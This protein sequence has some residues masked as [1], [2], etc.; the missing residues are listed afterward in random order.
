MIRVDIEKAVLEA[1]AELASGDVSFVVERP[2]TMDHGDYSTN[3]ALVAAKMLKNNPMEVAE[4][5]VEILETKYRVQKSGVTQS[6]DPR[7]FGNGVLLKES[8]IEYLKKIE[9][10]GAGF[11]NFHLSQSAIISEVARAVTDKSWGNNNLYAG[12]KVLIEYTSPNLFKPLHIGNLVGNIVGES[13][14]RLL[15]VG[16]AEVVRFNYPSDIGLTVAKGVWGLKSNHGDP[17][18]ILALGEAYRVG[19]TAYEDNDTAKKEIEDINR[20]LYAGSD[21][22]LNALRMAGIQTSRKHLAELCATLGTS[23]DAEIFESQS[24]PVGLEIVLAHLADDIFEKS[25]GAV[26]FHAEQINPK[27]HTRVFVNS[28]G[29]PTYEAKDIGLFSLKQKAYPNIDTFITVTGTE[30]KEYFKIIFTAIG[31]LFPDISQNKILRHIATGF[32]TLTTGKM[33]SRKGNVLTGESLLADLRDVAKEKMEGRTLAFPE[34][35]AEQIAVGAIKYSVLKQGSGKDITFDPQKALSLEGDSGP[36]LQ[37]ACVRARSLIK[38]AEVA[39]VIA[40]AKLVEKMVWPH[41]TPLT[42]RITLERT[43]IHFPDVVYRAVA[44]LEPHHLTTYLTELASAFNSWYANER[45]IDGPNPP[46]G[47][48]LATAVERT[49]SIGLTTLGIPTPEEM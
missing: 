24:S 25:E 9:V 19:N 26:V 15:E 32:L 22:E 28:Q 7:T 5:L 3:V 33:S 46:Y 17:A 12:R 39:G 42:P 29:L 13:V 41:L 11:I 6:R 47:L 45:I 34:K 21:E 36:Y 4:K 18:N 48:L 30:Q 49:L 14:A 40:E 27:L 20:A 1:I 43:L 37:Y 8:N 16:G 23:F 31:K 38:T 2:L 35:I 44:E 10:A